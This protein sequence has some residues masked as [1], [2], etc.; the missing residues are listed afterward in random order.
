MPAYSITPVPC[1]DIHL[2][3]VRV[4]EPLSI[5]D[6]PYSVIEARM[7]HQY[8][9]NTKIPIIEDVESP[10]KTPNETQ[11]EIVI[12]THPTQ[13]IREPRY[14]EQLTLQKIVEQP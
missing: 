6:V 14:P 11:G 5:E 3:S 4:V 9:S 10:T 8:P 1:N 2:R 7:N 12:E 13:L